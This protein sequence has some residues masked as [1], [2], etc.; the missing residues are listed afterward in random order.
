MNPPA[1]KGMSPAEIEQAATRMGLDN[2]LRN[3][4]ET[5][6][7]AAGRVGDIAALLPEPWTPVTHPAHNFTVPGKPR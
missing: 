6:H 4:P 7:R 3:F 5:L 2:A 1:T